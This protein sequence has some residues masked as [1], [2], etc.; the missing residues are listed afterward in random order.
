MIEIRDPA[1]GSLEPIEHVSTRAGLRLLV[2][3][4]GDA[5]SSTLKKQRNCGFLSCCVEITEIQWKCAKPIEKLVVTSP[6]S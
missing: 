3:E 6:Q 2:I 4:L 5:P 1:E